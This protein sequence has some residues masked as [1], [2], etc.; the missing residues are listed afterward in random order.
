MTP[1]AL[2]RRLYDVY[3]AGYECRNAVFA[4]HR[5]V[6]QSPW[7]TRVL[8]GVDVDKAFMRNGFF[9]LT[10]LLLKRELRRRV[11]RIPDPRIVEIGVG[12]FAVLSGWLSRHVGKHIVACDFD[13]IA[14][15][16]AKV[17]VRRN[18]L[19]IEVLRSNV[20]SAVPEGE[21]DLVFWNLPYYD[22]PEHILT[23]LFEAAPRYLSEDG[24]LILGFNGKPLPV[25]RVL[26]ILGRY[27]SLEVER[28]RSYWWNL[29]ALVCI[30]RAPF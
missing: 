6:I 1:T 25:A 7:V 12:R 16:S 22:D 28:V 27:P 5:R 13:R 20:L 2:L 26:E 21:R 24:T 11:R 18:D 10:T 17:H 29:H 9:D 15:E 23:S 19:D 4:V 14:F 30:R 8:F 3:D